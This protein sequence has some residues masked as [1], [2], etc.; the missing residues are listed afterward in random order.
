MQLNMTRLKRRKLPMYK[1]I[2]GGSRKFEKGRPEHFQS[3]N[4]IDRSHLEAILRKKINILFYLDAFR[5]I[6]EQ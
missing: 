2:K 4:R 1:V 6:L 3:R 5:G